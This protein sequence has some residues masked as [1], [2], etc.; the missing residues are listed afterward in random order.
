[1]AQPFSHQQELQPKKQAHHDAGAQRA[2][3]QAHGLLAPP[4][5]QPHQ[6]RGHTRA[7]SDL[8]DGCNVG[9]GGLEHHLLQAPN[10][11]QQRHKGD[12]FGVEV[13]AGV[14]RCDIE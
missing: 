12:G 13:Q 3:T 6:Q 2:V 4:H 9:C 7:Q 8:H 14:H 1:M 5:E 11:A 10:G